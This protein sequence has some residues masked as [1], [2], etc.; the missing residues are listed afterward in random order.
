MLGKGLDL[1]NLSVVG[2]ITAETSLTFPD[3]TSEERTYQLLSQALGRVN[4]G[5][6]PGTAIV[7]TYH[8]DSSLLRSAATKNYQNFYEGQLEERRLYGFPPFRF[9]LKLSCSRASSASARK[10][11]SELAGKLQRLY[12]NVE[13]I[14]PNPAFAEKTHGKY[15]W[16]IIIKAKSRQH[17]LDIIKKLPPNWSYDIDPLNL[18]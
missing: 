14:G 6:V 5:H 7:Q 17:L 3:Y 8:P 2:I 12:P 1:P 10:A 4:R 16:Q 13:V 18:L 15:H 11:S 9:L